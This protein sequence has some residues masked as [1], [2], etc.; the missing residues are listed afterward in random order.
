MSVP[1]ES[2][3]FF[4]GNTLRHVITIYDQTI[5]G[6]VKDLSGA[7]ATY[8]VRPAPHET[9]TF[10]LSSSDSPV[11]ITIN[12]PG[13]ILTV[14]GAGSLTT[15]LR[16]SYYYHVDVTDSVGDLATVLEGWISFK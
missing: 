14:V 13:G 2:F 16:G 5:G 9:A 12:A 8:T 7:N 3:D 15:T 10:T 4:A 11:T 6:S 1:T